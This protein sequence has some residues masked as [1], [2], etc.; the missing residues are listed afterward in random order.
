MATGTK[1]PDISVEALLADHTAKV[2]A[3]AERLRHIVRETIPDAAESVHGFWHSINYRHPVNGYFCGIF[4][5]TDAV[6]LVFE[7]GVL[8]PDPDG[9]LEG[10]GKQ[11]RQVR[12]TKAK[13]IR[14]RPLRKLLREAVDLPG[15]R[16]EKLGM[17]R[18]SA[19]LPAT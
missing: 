5:R 12:I 19:K 15:S 1:H 4:P 14:L 11:V 16:D 13:E 17:I 7:F 10:N 8:L 2:R 18:T 3:V 6:L 9:L